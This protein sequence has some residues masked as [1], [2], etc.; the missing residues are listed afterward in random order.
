[1]VRPNIRSFFK[2]WDTYEGSNKKKLRKAIQNNTKKVTHLSE[3]CGHYGEPG[4]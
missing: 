4:C 1:M 3:C 2:N